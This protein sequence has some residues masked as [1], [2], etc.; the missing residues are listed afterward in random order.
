MMLPGPDLKVAIKCNLKLG[1]TTQ[2]TT[3][4]FNIS[5]ID[6]NDNLI[7]VQDK[8]TNLTLNSPYFVKVSGKHPEIQ[9]KY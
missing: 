5:I 6:R 3:K 9:M 8:F 7:K 2:L 1:E 4:V